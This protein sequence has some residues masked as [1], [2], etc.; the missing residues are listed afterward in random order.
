MTTF[1]YWTWNFL[2]NHF[3]IPAYNT[4]LKRSIIRPL[5]LSRKQKKKKNISNALPVFERS[6]LFPPYWQTR[7]MIQI[8]KR[9]NQRVE[10]RNFKFLP[11]IFPVSNHKTGSPPGSVYFTSFFFFFFFFFILFQLFP[12]FVYACW[13]NQGITER[14]GYWKKGAWIQKW[15]NNVQRMI[16]YRMYEIW[17]GNICANHGS[18]YSQNV[19]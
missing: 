6:F 11:D 1:Q 16:S 8:F 18:W 9:A 14:E 10:N 3:F 17:G 15:L 2:K 7:R 5:F 13:S 19:R 4:I 12:A